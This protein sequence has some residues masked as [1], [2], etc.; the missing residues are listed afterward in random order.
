MALPWRWPSRLSD[1]RR[2]GAPMS[3]ADCLVVGA[4]PAGL[5]AAIYLARF[6][7]RVVIYDTGNSRAT[8]IPV[9]HNYAG[10]PHGISGNDLLARLREQAGRHGVQVQQ[11]LVESLQQERDRFIATV[12]G[13]TVR[14]SKVILAT[15]IVDKEPEIPNL[16]EAIRSGVIRLCAICD[17][18]DVID[19][20]IA[21]YGPAASAFKHARFMRTYSTDVTMLVPPGE[22]PLD[23]AMRERAEQ[24]GIRC[25]D[26]TVVQIHM[27][28]DHLAAVRT[29]SGAE[30]RFETLY[31]TLGCRMRSDLATA[32]GARCTDAGDIIVDAHMA[33][34]I[35]GLYAAGDVVAAL[36]QVNVAVGHAAIAATHVHNHLP[37]NFCN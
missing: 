33:T 15:G 8:Y 9:S 21:V 25:I 12:N 11:G 34:S 7:R 37:E 20:K 23:A 32:L 4:G 13:A 22:P 24:A 35:E 2:F 1:P 28:S 5:T 6:R 3:D 29:S 26:E 27:T 10:F 30:Y 18:Y 19:E 14:A 36:N 31:P 16:R 17:A